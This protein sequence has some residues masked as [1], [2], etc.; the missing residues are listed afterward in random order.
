ML[1][2]SELEWTGRSKWMRMSGRAPAR[3]FRQ[4]PRWR[5]GSDMRRANAAVRLQ[6]AGLRLG[7]T[8]G[9]GLPVH[10]APPGVEVIRPLVLIFQ[11]IGVLPDI[12]AH[13]RHL[14][15][16]VRVIL[17]GARED[18]ELAVG[19]DEPGQPLPKRLT[20]ASLIC[21]LKV[22]KSVKVALMSSAKGPL[23]SPPALGP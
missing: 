22:A 3:G 1:P 2:S 8:L 5:S 16:H 23:G 6:L 11:V 17:V 15:G 13:D 10:H 19:K 7:V 14:A 18:L 21:A 20:P 4:A 9:D 12:D